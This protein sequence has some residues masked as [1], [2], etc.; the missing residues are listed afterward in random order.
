MLIIRFDFI[1]VSWK[2]RSAAVSSRQEGRGK[3][4]WEQRW[5][6]GCWHRGAPP[7]RWGG[8]WILEQMGG[9]SDEQT[10]WPAQ[11]FTFTFQTLLL[12][13]QRPTKAQLSLPPNTPPC[14]ARAAGVYLPWWHPNKHNLRSGFAL[15]NAKKQRQIYL[16]LL[17]RYILL[18][19]SGDANN[20]PEMN[21]PHF[22]CSGFSTGF[23]PWL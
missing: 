23:K 20:I 21:H 15:L 13:H 19:W 11:R 17:G 16:E 6:Q 10:G 4:M 2:S 5:R 1:L 18:P 12:N 14:P 3:Q 22:L 8:A 9:G 7:H